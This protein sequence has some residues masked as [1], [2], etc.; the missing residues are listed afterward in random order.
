MFLYFEYDTQESIEAIWGGTKKGRSREMNKGKIRNET[1]GAISLSRLVARA[2]FFAFLGRAR[3]PR[4]DEGFLWWATAR[5]S[6]LGHPRI[7]LRTLAHLPARLH[8]GFASCSA[9]CKDSIA[10]FS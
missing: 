9:S 1:P 2:L 3:S 4:K 5:L 10:F 7:V 6:L 8:W